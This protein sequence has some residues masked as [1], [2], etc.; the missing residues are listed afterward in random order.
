M[1]TIE[2]VNRLAGPLGDQLQVRFSHVRAR[3]LQRLAALGPKTA[4][5]SQ[6]YLGLAML[7]DPQQ[8]ADSG[9]RSGRPESRIAGRVALVPKLGRP[10]VCGQQGGSPYI[11]SLGLGALLITGMLSTSPPVRPRQNAGVSPAESAE[12]PKLKSSIQRV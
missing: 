11:H 6:Q 8:A 12:E 4:E 9:G 1:K 7:A 5:K 2:Q 10:W 3:E